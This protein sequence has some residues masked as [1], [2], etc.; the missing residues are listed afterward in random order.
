VPPFIRFVRTKKVCPLADKHCG[1]VQVRFRFVRWRTKDSRAAVYQIRSCRCV[2][3]GR[4]NQHNNRNEHEEQGHHSET[5]Q[6]RA[7]SSVAWSL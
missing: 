3:S 6:L 2:D 5:H 1:R 7:V 4:R